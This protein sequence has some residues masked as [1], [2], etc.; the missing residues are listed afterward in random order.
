MSSTAWPT[1]A[2]TSGALA[3]FARPLDRAALA[4]M[5]A[6]ARER[7]DVQTVRETGS[8]NSDLLAAARAMQ[9]LRV[10]LRATLL[11][12]AGRGRHGRR[13][14]SSAG[15][16]LLFSLALPLA[17]SAHALSA[18]TL[19][20]GVAVA[21]MLHGDG[22]EVRL[23]WPNDVLL[24]DRKLAGILCELARDTSGRRTLV[25]GVGMNLWA[26]AAMRA[27]AAQPIATLAERIDLGSLAATREARIARLAGAILDTARAYEREGFV[28][29]QPRYM[30]WFAH[31]GSEVDILEQGAR[32]ARGRALGVDGDGR[33]LVQTADG[34][35]VFTS[36]ELSLRRVERAA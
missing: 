24:D 17:A 7:I 27:S 28:P 36:G 10:Q 16:S 25:V 2:P 13:W 1:Q 30:H 22:V 5:L 14:H 33:L 32:I 6:T 23:K 8:T 20:C 4:R 11:Q 15:A 29:L 31:E 3:A 26:D 9:P 35:R 34:M 18:I 12:S 19:A 21:E